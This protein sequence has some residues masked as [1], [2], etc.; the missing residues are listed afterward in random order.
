LW[1]ATRFVLQ[2][3]DGY[4]P[5][6]VALESLPLEDRW[7]LSRLATTTAAI[8]DF[9]EGYHFSDVARTLYE[10]IWSEFCDWYVEMSKGRLR[11]EAS[12]PLAQRVLV[13]VLD[14]ILRL[15]HPVMPFVT[16]SLWQALNEAAFERGVPAPEP[17]AESAMIA[18]WPSLPEA[19]RD[20]SM[21]QRIGRMQDLIRAVREIRNR[22]MIDPKTSLHVSVR[23]AAA[24][25]GDLEQLRPFIA[26]LGGVGQL[27][28]GPT[29]ARPPQSA[30]YIH[31]EFEAY[32]P[33][34]GLIDVAAEVKRLEKQIAEKR[35]H[36]H[37]SE[38]KLQNPNF[39]DK[40][41]AEVVQQ[42]R[43]AVAELHNQIKVMEDTLRELQGR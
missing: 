35:K 4:E 38:A 24:V 36:L 11:D 22:Y 15:A 27:A 30:S 20:A 39:K 3:L 9:L 25:A 7:I 13:G 10:F 12:R 23:C 28:A 34:A 43:D 17:S 6:A 16:E 8:T 2:N 19:W 32:V 33:L 37:G 21:E 42:Q 29:L 18:P 31:A 41:P 26:L 40:A 5:G 14:T 1:N